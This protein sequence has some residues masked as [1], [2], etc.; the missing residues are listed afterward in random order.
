MGRK[1]KEQK[2]EDDTIKKDSIEDEEK[3]KAIREIRNRNIVLIILSLLII[4]SF[5]SLFNLAGN[6]GQ[7]LDKSLINIIG[8][9]KW[10]LPIFLSLLLI[11]YIKSKRIQ[12]LASFGAIL[13]F[14]SILG[15]ISLFNLF[16]S[17]NNGGVVGQ[18]FL[19]PFQKFTGDLASFFILIAIILLG[20]AFIVDTPIDDYFRKLFGKKTQEEA[21]GNS[22]DINVPKQAEDETLNNKQ[23]PSTPVFNIQNANFVNPSEDNKKEKHI[24]TGDIQPTTLKKLN[25]PK[26]DLYL[27]IE[28]LEDRN[29]IASAGDINTNLMLI[30]KTL[31]NFGISV[32]MEGVKIGPTVTQY[33]FKPADGVKLSKIV[34][35]QNDLALALAANSLRIEAPIPGKS[36]VGIEVPNKVSAIVSMKEMITSEEFKTRRSNLSLLLGKD[37]S[38]KPYIVDLAQMPHLLIAGATG[39]GKSVAIHSIIAALMYQNS[40]DDLKFIMVDPKRVE[41]A[42]YNGIPYLLTPPVTDH[43]KI[44]NALKWAVGEMDRRYQVLASAKKI[45][46]SSY[47]ESVENEDRLPVIVIIIDELADLMMLYRAE[48]EPCIIRIAQ[49]ARAVGIHL[50]LATQRPSV[51]VIT[52]LIKANIPTRIAFMVAASVDSRTILDEI[53]A[54]RLLGKGDMLYSAPNTPKPIRLQGTYISDEETKRLTLHLKSMDFDVEYDNSIVEKKSLI[55]NGGI[56]NSG[57]NTDDDLFEEAVEEVKRAGRASTSLLQRKFR[58]GY[59]RAARL[60]DLLEEAGVVGPADGAK[61]REVYGINDNGEENDETD[62]YNNEIRE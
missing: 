42:L 4:I 49:L 10:F 20:I 47:N 62:D 16:P 25:I 40:P 39:T 45:N 11:L 28:L 48:V 32:T 37:V 23:Q 14:F 15:L 52:G 59:S 56:T 7:F 13:I 17:L 26:K 60:M 19:F 53:G 43:R 44:V 3:R 9:G 5:L 6:F 55:T 46:I 61:P 58:I 21:T 41:L 27:P 22:S 24:S 35:L 18:Y 29:S 2:K 33:S 54:E 8:F 51:N 50:V 38:G 36:L 12:K 34:A 31:D 1:K 30:Q 57:F